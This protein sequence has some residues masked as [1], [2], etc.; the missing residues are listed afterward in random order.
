[1]FNFYSPSPKAWSVKKFCKI[2]YV[3]LLNTPHPPHYCSYCCFCEWSSAILD[4]SWSIK[5]WL[6]TLTYECIWGT[7]CLLLCRLW[8]TWDLSPVREITTS[9]IAHP[10]IR[11]SFLYPQSWNSLHFKIAAIFFYAI[12][13][14]GH[15]MNAHRAD[16]VC[17]SICMFQLGNHWGNMVKSGMDLMPLEASP[18]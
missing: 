10:I 4:G 7:L 2:L 11:Y 12:F 5:I 14:C 17:P 15:K 9:F 18:I 6:M 1:M 3:F 13:V 8:S 16:H